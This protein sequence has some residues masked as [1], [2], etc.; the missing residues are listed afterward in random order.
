MECML[1]V[2]YR[3]LPS[4]LV[5]L[6]TVLILGLL[7]NTSHVVKWTEIYTLG[8]STKHHKVT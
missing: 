4:L 2:K 8:I 6:G 5:E 7:V 3:D 1:L